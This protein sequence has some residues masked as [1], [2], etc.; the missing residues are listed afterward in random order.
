[1]GIR[2]G[3]TAFKRSEHGFRFRN[4]F[5]ASDILR[6]MEGLGSVAAEVVDLIGGWEWHLCGG[7]CWAALD[8]YFEG[9]P[10]PERTDSPARGDALFEEL[11]RRQLD[12]LHG[13]SVIEKF[14]IWQAKP[15]T[16]SRLQSHSVGHLT[17][18]EEWP[19]VKNKLD[20]V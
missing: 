5:S 10:V 8:R 15:D 2:T 7:I 9:K 1:M 13:V 11:V 20:P 12:S 18:T 14:L 19:R 4:E 16:G 3:T 17:Q 6:E